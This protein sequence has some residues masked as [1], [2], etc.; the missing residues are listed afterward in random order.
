MN[1]TQRDMESADFFSSKALAL[2]PTPRYR[3][4]GWNEVYSSFTWALRRMPPCFF[5]P[6]YPSGISE[7]SSLLLLLILEEELAYTKSLRETNSAI[8][9]RV[10]R[11]RVKI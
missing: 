1:A 8:S 3:G 5:N 2:Q 10:R 4:W 11:L 9:L 6:L 7:Q